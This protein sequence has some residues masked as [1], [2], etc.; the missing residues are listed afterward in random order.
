MAAFSACCVPVAK[1]AGQQAPRAVHQPFTQRQP[2]ASSA[3]ST[4][5]QDAKPRAQRRSALVVRASSSNGASSSGNGA[6]QVENL[7]IIGS[8]PAGYTAAIY[9]ARANLRPLVYEGV[10]AGV[11]GVAAGNGC[12]WGGVGLT[13]QSH[14]WRCSN[15]EAPAAAVRVLPAEPPPPPPHHHP[16][17]PLPLPRSCLPAGGVRGGQLMTTT[18][19]ENFPGFPDGITGPDLMERMRAQAERW[20]STLN[21]EDVESVDFSSRPFTIR[22][23]D[24]TVRAHSVII[25]TGATAR[26]LG[27]PSEQQFWSA[28][29]SACAICD[30]ASHIF[31]QQQLA[32][33]GG[34]DTATEEA[35]YLTKYASH[36]SKALGQS[37]S[38]A[39]V[40]P[41]VAGTGA[42][43]ALC[44]LITWH[45]TLRACTC[46][47]VGCTA[48]C[49]P[50]AH[51][52]AK[53]TLKLLPASLLMPACLQVHLLVRGD[54]MRASG[55]MQDRVLSNPKITVHFNTEVADAYGDSLLQGLHLKDT[56]TG[57][58][59]AGWGDRGRGRKEGW[60]LERC[61]KRGS[62]AA[63]GCHD[64]PVTEASGGPGCI[65]FPV[66][67]LACLQA[68]CVTCQCAACST[69][70]ATSPTL[71]SWG[72]RS[73]W[74]R[75]ATW[76][77]TRGLAP[78]LRESS[79]RGIC[80]TPSGARPSPRRAAAAWRR[81]R[82]SD[83]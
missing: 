62:R 41:A 32:V 23:T 9:A 6:E 61:S 77:C 12:G 1:A 55:A 56:K 30:G 13:S 34:G 69:A 17:T 65:F 63:K 48:H 19:V 21:T 5:Q 74:M 70:S 66:C 11:L 31:K 76:W 68:R 59:R 81:C 82:R 15:T 49:P 42:A 37:L 18:E 44:I 24:T 57:A 47:A 67:S 40:A 75:G 50:P 83:T 36:V 20:G 25:A 26:R 4:R 27:I 33:A 72:A 8:G 14:S 7:V 22:G 39:Q 43:G 80:M 51:A 60:G 45:Q 16:A 46:W 35:I 64:A 3:P 53:L 38:L 58:Q 73:S 2:R 78:T 79:L 29:I 71:R 28:G 54:R 52:A 10:S